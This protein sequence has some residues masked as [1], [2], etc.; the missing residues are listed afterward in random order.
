MKLVSI[1]FTVIESIFVF[2]CLASNKQIW[3]KYKVYLKFFHFFSKCA[4]SANF[5]Q[6]LFVLY[7]IFTNFAL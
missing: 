2:C 7:L 5:A 1:F 3:E 6:N 4:D